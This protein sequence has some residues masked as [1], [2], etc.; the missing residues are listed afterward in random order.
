MSN[1]AAGKFLAHV[2]TLIA[3][4]G[5]GEPFDKPMLQWI[6]DLADDLANKVAALELIPARPGAKIVPT[7][8]EYNTTFIDMRTH[9]KPSARVA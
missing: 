6:A 9:I 3:C 7:L 8:E 5:I 1:H 4:R 2:E